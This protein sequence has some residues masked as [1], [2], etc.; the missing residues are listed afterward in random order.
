ML[1]PDLSSSLTWDF[2]TPPFAQ[3]ALT[4]SSEEFT[5]RHPGHYLVYMLGNEQGS[6]F[7]FGTLEGGRLGMSRTLSVAPLQKRPD[8]NPFAMMITLGRAPNNDI[9]VASGDIS[10]FHAYL[11]QIGTEWRLADAGSSFGTFVDGE[12]LRQSVPTPIHEGSVLSF[13][14]MEARLLSSASL[15]AFLRAGGGSRAARAS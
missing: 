3:D 4:L 6:D 9:E 2:A 15:Q 13:A 7:A 14:S 5:A 1:Q 8:G 10:K 12:R 11:T